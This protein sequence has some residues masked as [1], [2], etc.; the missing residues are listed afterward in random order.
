MIKITAKEKAAK[1][2]RK[3][4]WTLQQIGDKLGVSHEWA[5]QLVRKY[6]IKTVMIKRYKKSLGG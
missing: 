1:F 2:L 3:T 5:R 6:D 4:G